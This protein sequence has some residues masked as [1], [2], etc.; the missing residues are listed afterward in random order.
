M[1]LKLLLAAFGL[2]LF[3]EGAIYAI[4]PDFMRKM[5]AMMSKLPRHDI[6]ITG[7]ITAAAGAVLVMLALKAA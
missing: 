6:T 1:S 2:M 3:F 4:A 5:S 7:L